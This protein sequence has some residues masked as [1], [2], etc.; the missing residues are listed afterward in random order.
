MWVVGNDK[1]R[2][3]CWGNV[4]GM[5]HEK[6][7]EP[8][9]VTALYAAIDDAIDPPGALDWDTVL[10]VVWFGVDRDPDTPVPRDIVDQPSP[11]RSDGSP[12]D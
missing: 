10:R 9:E 4:L 3:S 7:G 12:P 2:S 5:T 11:R 6:P 8:D 1:H